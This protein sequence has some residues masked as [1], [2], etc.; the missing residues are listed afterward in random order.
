M[1]SSLGINIIQLPQS[2][3]GYCQTRQDSLHSLGEVSI[4]FEHCS[5]SS[6]NLQ[7][8]CAT[9]QNAWE[10]RRQFSLG[11]RF[12]RGSGIGRRGGNRLRPE[13][14]PRWQKAKTNNEQGEKCILIRIFRETPK[15]ELLDSHY[16]IRA[17]ECSRPLMPSPF[18]KDCPCLITR[19]DTVAG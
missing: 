3:I 1:D 12:R 6:W 2:M 11:T 13:W 4:V 17:E 14:F 16:Q 7:L 8:R 15:I 19:F 5:C 9:P 18:H 10:S